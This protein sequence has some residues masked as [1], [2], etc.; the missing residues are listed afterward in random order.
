MEAL[1]EQLTERNFDTRY[2][3]ISEAIHCHL[4]LF[5]VVNQNA[6]DRNR[7]QKLIVHSGIDSGAEKLEL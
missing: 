3:R 5:G 7:R 1:I 4:C 6:S 2:L